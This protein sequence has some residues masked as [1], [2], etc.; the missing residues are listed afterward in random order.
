M[1]H[2]AYRALA[3]SVWMVSFGNAAG[4]S[5][6]MCPTIACVPRIDLTYSSVVPDPYRLTVTLNNVSVVENCPGTR[7]D[8]GFTPGVASCDDRHATIT[9]VDL[10]HAENSFIGMDV[11]FGGR[12]SSGTATLQDIVNSRDCDLVCYQHVGTVFN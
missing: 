4:C 10:G 2:R 6:K 12:L 7:P 11:S 1:G 9:G 3:V 8:L 5:E